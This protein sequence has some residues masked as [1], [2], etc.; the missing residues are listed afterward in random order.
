ML[1]RHAR[2]AVALGPVRDVLVVS[3]VRLPALQEE[4][5]V[6]GGDLKRRRRE[7]EDVALLERAAAFALA[8]G[9]G[10]RKIVDANDGHE[11]PFSGRV[12]RRARAETTC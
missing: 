5:A 8:F 2:H 1:P 12:Y 6:F 7:E 9:T 11:L 3:R 4:R 10:R